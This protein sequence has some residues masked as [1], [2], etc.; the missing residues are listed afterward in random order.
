MKN[1]VNRW[2]ARALVVFVT[3]GF[4]VY[5]LADISSTQEKGLAQLQTELVGTWIATVQG[6]TRP[7][8]L[9]ILNV[10]RKSEN[11]FS[12]EAMFGYSDIPQSAA[13]VEIEQIATLR[14]LLL[15][16]KSGA[17]IVATQ[18]QKETF[19]GRLVYPDGITKVVSLRK[20]PADKLRA[21]VES[22]HSSPELLL[23]YWS[24]KDC[25]WCTYWES[26]WSGMESG[27]KS[28]EEFKKLTYRVIK[29]ARLA[30]PYTDEHFASDLKWLKERIDSGEERNLGRPGWGFYVN[31]VRVAS[32]YGTNYWDAKIFPEIRLLVA[33]YSASDRP[34][35]PPD[36]SR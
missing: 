30:D 22:S 24:S 12:L 25:T 8:T 13:D 36:A 21:K 3:C 28:S 14:K 19:S 29:N 31:K 9:N 18:T 10:L 16:A 33:K 32:F 35:N 11:T 15:T 2:F 23:V 34:I 7:R 17:K 20:L 26:S 27:L 1:V 4:Q 5:A 6:D